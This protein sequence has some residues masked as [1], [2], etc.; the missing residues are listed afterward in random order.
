MT[1]FS[2]AIDAT[3][4]AHQ[5]VSDLLAT[6][7]GELAAEEATTT[8]LT[9]EAVVAATDLAAEKATTKRLLAEAVAAAAAKATLVARV[10]DL[11]AQLAK[12]L[13]ELAALKPAAMP[14]GSSVGA[15]GWSAVSSYATKVSTPQ[16]IRT[17][18]AG[19]L[20]VMA[21]ACATKYPGV[22][23]VY[24]PAA[25]GL[26]D[27]QVVSALRE[28]DG[29][30]AASNGGRMWVC[31]NPEHDRHIAK[32]ATY[33]MAQF[34][35]MLAQ[36]FRLATENVPSMVKCLW[37]NPTGYS[38]AAR[39]KTYV[40]PVLP[41]VAGI[42]VN[43]YSWQKEAGTATQASVTDATWSAKYARDHGKNFAMMEQG[44]E[45]G[46]LQAKLMTDMLAVVTATKPDVFIYWESVNGS[47]DSRLN[48]EAA[49]VLKAAIAT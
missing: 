21:R 32:E 47:I 39:F 26:S 1:I 4:A 8:R 28:L 40:E 35:A 2:E 6:T 36:W 20:N 37:V 3:I 14:W 29:I 19:G 48:P 41:Y 17:Y 12:A 10:D 46:A 24:G 44:C 43:G 27:T 22:P 33:T 18:A 42:G 38:A 30:R 25:I 49:A 9:A 45:V 16:A 5:V 7:D 23:Q 11:S 34:T 31:P 15:E 13:A